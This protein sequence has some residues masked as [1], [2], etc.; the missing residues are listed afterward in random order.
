MFSKRFVKCLCVAIVICAMLLG[1]L[2]T[3]AINSGMLSDAAENGKGHAFPWN[4]LRPMDKDLLDWLNKD[5][6]KN[7][8][9]DDDDSN[10]EEKILMHVQTE[11]DEEYLYLK[12]QSFGDYL[13]CGFD[14]D[15]S[16]Y[17]YTETLNGQ[18]LSAHYLQ[19][20]TTLNSGSYYLTVEPKTEG[21]HRVI[22]YY[23]RHNIQA[24]IQTSDMEATGSTE[25]TY[26]M[27]FNS[28]PIQPNLFVTE[29]NAEYEQNYRNHV[30]GTYLAIDAET[31]AVMQEI[32]N[33]LDIQSKSRDE[34][35]EIISEYV[36]NSAT[37]NLKYDTALDSEANRGVAFLTNEKYTEGICEHYAEAATLLLRAAGIPSRYTEGYMLKE[38][39]GGYAKVVTEMD[40]HAWVEIYTD[41]I[42]WEYLEVTPNTN[43]ENTVAVTVNSSVSGF[44][45]LKNKAYGD[46][47]LT[48]KSWTE[49]PKYPSVSTSG[50]CAD[51]LY[52]AMTQLSDTSIYS[53]HLTPRISGTYYMPYYAVVPTEGEYVQGDDTLMSGKDEGYTVSFSNGTGSQDEELRSFEIEYSSFAS[54]NYKNVGDTSISAVLQQI[55]DENSLNALDLSDPELCRVAMIRV[56]SFFKSNYTSTDNETIINAINDSNNPIAALLNE[57]KA[58][59]GRQFAEAATLMYRQLGLPARLVSGLYDKVAAGEDTDIYLNRTHFW[60]EVYIA[61][62]G[63]CRSEVMPYGAK[64]ELI[65]KPMPYSK[66]WTEADPKLTSKDIPDDQYMITASDESM[67]DKIDDYT[68]SFCEIGTLD[69]NGQSSY[70]YGASAITNIEIRR[71]SDGALVYTYIDG[72]E[73]LHYPDEISVSL[74]N[75]ITQLYLAELN[76]TSEN[77]EK[78]YD[79]T[80]LSVQ[81]ESIV[82]EVVD[83]DL[84][85]NGFTCEV[86]P[87]GGRI[88]VGDSTASFNVQ[89]TDSNGEIRNSWFKINRDFGVL[90]VTPREI[91]LTAGSI[92][93]TLAQT[94][95]QPIS[96]NSY[97]ITIGELAQGDTLTSVT[98]EGTVIIGSAENI[99]TGVTI[100][101]AEGTD[102][103][104]NYT[105]NLQSGTLT[106]NPT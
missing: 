94:G 42:G 23:V 21:L 58:G 37:Y 106:V 19:Q 101:N 63:W 76:I 35:V 17:E 16:K 86:T 6:D 51:Y 36:M 93:Q 55:I 95:G 11:R 97:E 60:V 56:E 48:T 45:Y 31:E 74:E 78:V 83:Y 8:D 2:L 39:R 27:W 47:D 89:L 80:A 88:N 10:D 15:L 103:T 9:K 64:T 62:R 104:A 79:G 52:A 13:G 46:Y 43:N 34:A 99:I 26:F 38:L 98:V 102:V 72:V 92:T 57:Y 18:D 68:V 70:G 82:L 53:M 1:V 91:E 30:Y 69:P 77:A 54:S 90:S 50:M 71:V 32:L 61:G 49:A 40:A 65:I 12:T 73:T 3:F 33:T 5:T 81:K 84:A 75:G 22:P 66:L 28:D 67:V 29:A 20:F 85:A 96:L 7:D 14:G 44:V 100:S 24:D 59:N 105:I 41:G 4:M 25:D 87:T